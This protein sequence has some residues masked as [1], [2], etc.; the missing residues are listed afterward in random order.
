M[1]DLL[2]VSALSQPLPF[3]AA[4]FSMDTHF[5]CKGRSNLLRTILCLKR[6]QLPVSGPPVPTP[7]P[8]PP[9]RTSKWHLFVCR[10]WHT[11]TQGRSANRGKCSS[12]T[13]GPKGSKDACKEKRAH[14]TS[15]EKCPW[16]IFANRQDWQKG[17]KHCEHSSASQSI[18][19]NLNLN[20]HHWSR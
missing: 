6:C 9:S 3:S 16:W 1:A 12:K 19:C 13:K 7:L 17:T 18:D 5:T 11:T 20:S 14:S 2:L 10:V 4:K 15:K 8:L